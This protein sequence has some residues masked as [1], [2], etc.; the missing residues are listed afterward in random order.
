MMGVSAKTLRLE[1]C[2]PSSIYTT[3][4]RYEILYSICRALPALNQS[5]SARQFVNQTYHKQKWQ[6]AIGGH[7][8]WKVNS[9]SGLTFRVMIG[10]SEELCWAGYML[11][12]KSFCRIS[13]QAFCRGSH[14]DL[15]H[16]V[17]RFPLFQ[18][19]IQCILRH[20]K[21]KK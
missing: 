3:H 20:L 9:T 11:I 13:H 10:Y 18:D 1:L 19:T 17:A 8:Y 7:R 15:R 14:F 21:Q 16:F 6:I 12:D 5:M 2:I 4:S